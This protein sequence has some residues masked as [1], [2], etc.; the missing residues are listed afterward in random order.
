VASETDGPRGIERAVQARSTAELEAMDLDI[1][2][3]ARLWA[4]LLQQW[5]LPEA[6]NFWIVDVLPEINRELERRRRPA[7]AIPHHAG[8]FARIKAAI[9]LED[10]AG[11]F[12][13]LQSCGRDRLRGLCPIHQEKTASFYVYTNQQRWHC[14]GACSSGGDVIDLAERLEGVVL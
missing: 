12:T 7:P 8:W 1:P 10:Y 11:R 14:F 4:I 2:Y 5:G 13:Q 3:H 9:R 6:P